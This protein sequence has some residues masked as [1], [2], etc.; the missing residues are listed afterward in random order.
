MKLNES[1]I[2]ELYENGY[3]DRAISKVISVSSSTIYTWRILNGLP[4]NFPRG[5]PVATCDDYIPEESEIP[6]KDPE[7]LFCD[8]EFLENLMGKPLTR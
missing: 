6:W 4:A 8:L 5:N 3:S 2:R 1:K 7:S